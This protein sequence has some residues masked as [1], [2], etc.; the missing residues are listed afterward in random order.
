M[1]EARTTLKERKWK[2]WCKKRTEAAAVSAPCTKHFV[3]S[4]NCSKSL[5]CCYSPAHTGKKKK[6]KTCFRSRNNKCKQMPF[7]SNTERK[8]KFTASKKKKAWEVDGGVQ[9]WANRR[10]ELPFRWRK[11]SRTCQRV[12]FVRLPCC[13]K[14]ANNV[15]KTGDGFDA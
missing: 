11:L 13:I 6:K 3:T 9:P 7:S 1:F 15:H 8:A 14:Q 4:I 2:V 5:I 10:I 12:T